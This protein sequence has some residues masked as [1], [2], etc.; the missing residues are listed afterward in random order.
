MHVDQ[1]DLILSHFYS[2]LAKTALTVLFV[3]YKLKEEFIFNGMRTNLSK[4]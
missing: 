1:L 3:Y 2:C 4:S